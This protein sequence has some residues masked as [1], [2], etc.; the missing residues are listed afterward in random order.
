MSSKCKTLSVF[1]VCVQDRLNPSKLF[2]FL[3]M[4][5][6]IFGYKNEENK[7]ISISYRI[8]NIKCWVGI[9]FQNHNLH[10]CRFFASNWNELHLF[11]KYP[12]VNRD[13]SLSLSLSNT[14]NFGANVI[15]THHS[16]VK[17][18]QVLYTEV[19]WKEICDTQ[20]QFLIWG[21]DDKRFCYESF[22]LFFVLEMV[23]FR[24]CPMSFVFPT[25]FKK[26][27]TLN[28]VHKFLKINRFCVNKS[29]EKSTKWI[30]S[31]EIL[32]KL[33]IVTSQIDFVFNFKN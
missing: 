4:Q 22:F 2:L 21:R 5:Q 32:I 16:L 19:K 28:I 33:T 30:K 7:L 13:F 8:V 12:K 3:L 11:L 26:F 20:A 1:F 6:V 10:L 9:V 27:Q 29:N 23:L 25:I 15:M 17:C 31:P 18:N 24:S 14:Q